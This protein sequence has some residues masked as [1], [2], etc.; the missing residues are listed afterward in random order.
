MFW[1]IFDIAVTWLWLLASSTPD[2]CFTLHH[3]AT[4]TRGY[5]FKLWKPSCTSGIVIIDKLEFI[6]LS[7]ISSRNS[8][9]FTYFLSKIPKFTKINEEVLLNTNNHLKQAQKAT[10]S[11]MF[12]QWSPQT[13]E[14]PYSSNFW[15][16]KTLVNFPLLAS[17]MLVNEQY[18]KLCEA[19]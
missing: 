11:I 9:K 5:Q 17:K 19:L 18:S 13:Q 7:T 15:Q 3:I 12:P 14:I 1:F 16:M 4:P 8:F 2:H 10:D 6:I